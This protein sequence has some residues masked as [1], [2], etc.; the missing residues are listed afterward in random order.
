[1]VDYFGQHGVCAAQ[2]YIPFIIRPNHSMTS[3]IPSALCTVSLSGLLELGIPG[4]HTNKPLK[5]F[6]QNIALILSLV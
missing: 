4:T 2:K 1:M 5:L 6:V 3:K